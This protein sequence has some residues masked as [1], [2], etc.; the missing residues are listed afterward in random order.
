VELQK[1]LVCCDHCGKEVPI[2]EAYR[3]EWKEINHYWY[4]CN[5]CE[6]GVFSSKSVE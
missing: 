1:K 2:D 5:K 4:Y 6:S 3:T